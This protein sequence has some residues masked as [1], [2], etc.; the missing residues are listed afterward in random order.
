MNQIE[1]QVIAIKMEMLVGY[2]QFEE[3][4]D[5]ARKAFPDSLEDNGIAW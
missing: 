1:D 3:V 4:N 5:A 2:D